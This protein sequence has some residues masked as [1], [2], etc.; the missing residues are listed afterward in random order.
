MSDATSRIRA[1]F[2]RIAL[3]T[4]H[5]GW[6]QNGHYHD[7]LLRHVPAGCK[8]A[9]EIG[10]GAG[11]FA[12]LLAAH[13]ESV[14]ALDL[15][16]E[17]IRIA[18][19]Q[20]SKELANI[21]FQVADVV[22]SELPDDEFDC[23]VSVTTMHHLPFASVLSKMKRALKP[24]GVILILDLYQSEGFYDAV[25]RALAY[26]V[27]V[28]LRLV[29]QGRL[30]PPAEVRRAWAEHEKYDSY[31]TLA[32]IRRACAEILPGAR[33]R[34]HLLWRYSIVWKKIVV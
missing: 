18:R 34:K 1:E 13:S 32:E 20:Q 30:R 11:G 14:L 27:S 24:S 8:R 7:F 3:V 9:L 33:V 25:T 2:D 31:L 12:R 4:N 10:C 17:M 23:I 15:S 19:T 26:P 5:S 16:P 22:S 21:D 6:S 29:N 28:S